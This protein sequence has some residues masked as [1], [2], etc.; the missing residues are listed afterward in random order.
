MIINVTAEEDK[1][2]F[3]DRYNL[4]PCAWGEGGPIVRAPWRRAGLT[5][6]EGVLVAGWGGG[7][8]VGNP[9]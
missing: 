8:T 4:L 5:G 6:G 1:G 2:Y 7:I 9:D 3:F